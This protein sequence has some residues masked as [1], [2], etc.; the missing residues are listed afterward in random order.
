MNYSKEKIEAIATKTTDLK[1]GDIVTVFSPVVR[2]SNEESFAW[3]V[4]TTKEITGMCY[5]NTNR[6]GCIGSD[7]EPNHGA[8]TCVIGEDHF[9]AKTGSNF[10]YVVNHE[11]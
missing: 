7:G 6:W 1:L 3:E 9:G 8:L 5:D 4:W 10:Y 2:E 11:A